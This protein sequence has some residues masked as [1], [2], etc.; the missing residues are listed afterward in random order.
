MIHKRLIGWK[1]GV[2]GWLVAVIVTLFVNV[3]LLVFA[4][5]GSNSGF[6]NGIGTLL[7]DECSKI[8]RY[9][10]SA[11][12]IINALSTLILSGSNYCMQ[13][14]SAPT[15]REIDNAHKRGIAL[16]IGIPSLRNL[17]VLGRWKVLIARNFIVAASFIVSDFAFPMTLKSFMP[18]AK[19]QL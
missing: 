9:N 16:D 18:N 4:I 14:L 5:V 10:I 12:L 17:A 8:T 7:Q 2:I 11:H 15:R 1:F 13:C 19:S 6:D 3:G